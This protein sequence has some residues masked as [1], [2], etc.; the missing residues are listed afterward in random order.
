MFVCPVDSRVDNGHV[1]IA[2]LQG[3]QRPMSRRS[4]CLPMPPPTAQLEPSHV[5]ELCLRG[6][7]H[8]IYID[9]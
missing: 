4:I 3:E 8:A 9:D 2:Q 6:H 1:G 5:V 7:S